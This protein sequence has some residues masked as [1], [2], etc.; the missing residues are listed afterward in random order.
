MDFEAFKKK[1][2]EKGYSP[3]SFVKNMGISTSNITNWK[4]GGNPS[5][6]V[7]A[8]IASELECSVGYLLGTETEDQSIGSLFRKTIKK[9]KTTPYRTITLRSDITI[10]DDSMKKIAEFLNTNIQ[11]LCNSDAVVYVPVSSEANH[12]KENSAEIMDYLIEIFDNVICD[13]FFKMIQIQ[14]SRIVL[15]NLGITSSGQIKDNFLQDKVNFILTGED[16]KDSLANIGF[17]LSDLIVLRHEFDKSL[18]FMFT[19]QV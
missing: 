14:I 8:K 9:M 13:S 5:F 17:T 2:K 10:E 16:S 18:K 15:Y 6:D 1:C 19:G 12:S 7:L 3:S 4:N 11:F